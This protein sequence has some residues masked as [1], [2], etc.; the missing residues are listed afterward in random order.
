MVVCS[1]PEVELDLEFGGLSDNLTRKLI[2]ALRIKLGV[3]PRVL[4]ELLPV[5]QHLVSH[6][7]FIELLD[8]YIENVF[9]C[10][11]V[12]ATNLVFNH[13]NIVESSGHEVCCEIH[14]SGHE[15]LLIRVLHEHVGDDAC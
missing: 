6:G 2:N 1:L 8:I 5:V 15:D 14:G 12:N 11:A 10:S 7:P 13:L 9:G 4:V 3:V